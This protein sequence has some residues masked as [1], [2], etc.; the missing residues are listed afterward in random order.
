[1]VA[2]NGYI[3]FI[4]VNDIGMKLEIRP[5][6]M[7]LI[8]IPEAQ[9]S[10][11]SCEQSILSNPDGSAS[12]SQGNSSVLAAVYGPAEVKISKEKVETTT[13]EVIFK[14]KVGLPGCADRFNERLIKDSCESAILGSLHPR[15]SV[16]II[17]QEMQNSG[18]LLSCCVN[19]TCLA[20][21]DASVPLKHLIAAVS[22]IVSHEDELILHPSVQQESDC[23][24]SMTYAFES[25]NYNIVLATQ[26]GCIQNEQIQEAM[27]LCR[28][29]SKRVFQFYRDSMTKK[30]SKSVLL[31][32]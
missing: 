3:F 7:A 16:N 29:A 9:V 27:L 23:K 14:P 26:N 8:A 20:L 21:L 25:S 18:S 30:L 11:I 19:S 28:E 10:D 4:S 1:M 24:A 17:L 31:E 12:F 5:T 6:D 32:K 13:V 22:C 2:E 15:S